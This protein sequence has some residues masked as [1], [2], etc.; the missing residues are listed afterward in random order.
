M[1]WLNQSY[2]ASERSEERERRAVEG[3]LCFVA[4]SSDIMVGFARV[5]TDRATFG[6]LCDVIVD[7]EFRG[8]GVGKALVQAVREHPDLSG[9]RIMLATKDAQGLYSSFGFEVLSH[10][11]EWMA[12]RLP[13]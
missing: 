3:S 6:W 10:P 8:L 12:V 7:P 2:W 13:E 5:V 4:L 9:T 11:D 1:A